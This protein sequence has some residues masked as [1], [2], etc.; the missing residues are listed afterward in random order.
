MKKILLFRL[1]FFVSS[2]SFLLYNL[3][4]LSFII[5]FFLY[6]LHLFN[7]CF[8]FLVS[9][10][11]FSSLHHFLSL[12]SLNSFFPSF[13]SLIYI[14]TYLSVLFTFHFGDCLPFTY[15]FFSVLFPF[16]VFLTL[17]YCLLFFM[18]WSSSAIHMVCLL[19]ETR[20]VI[21]FPLFRFEVDL[22][23]SNVFTQTVEYG[24]NFSAH[25]FRFSLILY[26]ETQRVWL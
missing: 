24:G 4:S 17:Y 26:E 19:F 9:T 5:P 3:R 1:C 16:F 2:L 25:Q 13:F 23:Q 21:Q 8:P 22:N 6:F 12:S 18:S 20:Y 14:P 11:Y 7:I 15:L 10:S